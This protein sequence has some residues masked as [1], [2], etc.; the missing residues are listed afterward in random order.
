M[1]TTRRLVWVIALLGPVLWLSRG[2]E[3]TVQGPV[4]HIQPDKAVE[5]GLWHQ[6]R[7]GENLRQIS[8]RY[9]GSHHQWRLIQ[10]CNDTG[11][12]PSPG[13][14]LWIPSSIDGWFDARDSEAR[15]ITEVRPV[16]ESDIT[17][18]GRDAGRQPSGSH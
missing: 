7:A 4:G 14:R 17:G 10:T 13:K 8:E 15:L 18:S 11:I 16:D 5:G 1:G 3:G 2:G 6:V 12:Y 9:Y